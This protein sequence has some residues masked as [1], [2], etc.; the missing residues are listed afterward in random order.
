MDPTEKQLDQWLS[1]R[2][3]E[4]YAEQA[5]EM[6]R[7]RHV[8]ERPAYLKSAWPATPKAFRRLLI[9]VAEHALEQHHGNMTR[10]DD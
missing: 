7:E 10:D 5:Y 3:A 2:T 9:T 1:S 8:G 4:E 6:V